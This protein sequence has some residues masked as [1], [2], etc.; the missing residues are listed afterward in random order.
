MPRP[1]AGTP[2]VG[3]SLYYSWFLFR[4]LSFPLGCWKFTWFNHDSK[5][6][7]SI[8]WVGSAPGPG[9]KTSSA[10]PQGTYS[11]WSFIYSL[12]STFIHSFIHSFIAPSSTCEWPLCSVGCLLYSH[13]S[14][15]AQGGERDGPA[16]PWGRKDSAC[17]C[18]MINKIKGFQRTWDV[19]AGRCILKIGAEDTESMSNL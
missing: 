10:S 15:F 16:Q 11:R 14:L 7:M 4:H 19:L 12:I 2:A 1:Q 17:Q 18:V 9:T 6:L 13:H 5:Y 8:Y 3:I